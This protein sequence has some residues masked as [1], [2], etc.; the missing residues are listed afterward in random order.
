MPR[1]SK[2]KSSKHSSKELK[3]YSDSEKDLSFKDRKGKEESG[4]V[5]VS[6]DLISSEKRKLESKDGK[7][8]YSASGNGDYSDEYSSS[9]RRKDRADERATDRWNGGDDDHRGSGEGSKKSSKA[10][11][12]TKSKRKDENMGMYEEIEELKKGSSGGK[13]EGRHRDRDSSRKE[14][15]DGGTERDREKEKDRE[16]KTKEGRSEKSVGGDEHRP[17]VKQVIENTDLDAQGDLGSPEPDNLLERRMR[18]K[19]DSSIDYEKHQDDIGEFNNR[20]LSSREDT[21]KDGKQ[22]DEKRKD[23]RYK[24]KYR[25]EI[26]DRDS[27]HRDDRPKDERPA[28]DHLSSRSEDKHVKDE[29]DSAEM[30]NKKSKENDRDRDRHREL[31]VRDRD[32]HREH[33][34]DRG[35]DRDYDRDHDWDWDRDRDRDGDRDRERNRDRDRERERERD[36]ERDRDRDYDRDHDHDFDRDYVSSHLDDRAS[37]YKDST[38]AKKRSPDDRDD[39]SD[40][41]SRGSKARYSD[42][43][44][45]A[46]SGDRLDSDANKGRSHSRQTLVDPVTSNEKRRK[47]PSSSPRVGVDEYRHLNSDDLKYRE[48]LTD[49][50]SKGFPSKD[51]SGFSTGL[52]KGPK[53]RSMEKSTKLDDTLLGE[54]SNEK[55]SSSKASP[56]GLI[57]RS[58]SSSSIDRRY[59]NRSGAR[60]SLDIE[61]TGRRN[62]ASIDNRDFGASDDRHSRDLPSEKPLADESSP[63]DSNFYNRPNQGNS[64][65]IPSHSAF[66]AGVDSPFMGSHEDDGRMNSNARY[67][68]GDLNMGRGH[69]NAWRGVTNWN[70][71]LPNGFMPFQPGPPHAG[72]QGMMTQFPGPLFGVRPSLEI[73]H[74]GIPYHI[75]DADR[76]SSPMRPLGWQNMMDGSGPSHLHGWDNNGVFRDEPHLYAA[77]EWDQNRHP[78]NS[79]ARESSVDVWKGQNGDTKRDLRSPSHK[80]EATVDDGLAVQI[81][82]MSNQEDNRGDGI[83]GKFSETRSGATSSAEESTKVIREKK[84]GPSKSTKDN[85]YCLSR[86]YLSKLDISVELAR[87]ELYSQCMS[88]LNIDQSTMTDEETTVRIMSKDHLRA[89]VKSSANTL[90]SSHFPCVKK[91]VFQLVDVVHVLQRAMDLYKKQRTEA[92]GVP[93]LSKR[94]LNVVSESES[95]KLEVHTDVEM[96]KDLVPTLDTEMADASNSKMDVENA[97]PVMPVVSEVKSEPVVS[98][99]T[100]EMQNHNPLISPKLEVPT[101]ED[102]QEN[103]EEPQ[104]IFKEVKTE[105]ISSSEQKVIPPE[106]STAEIAAAAA[107]GA[108]SPDNASLPAAS[109][110]VEGEHIDE[111]SSRAN[112]GQSVENEEEG[113]TLGD[114]M[115][116]PVS[117]PGETSPKDCEAVMSGSN[118]SESVNLSR[119][120][121]SPESTH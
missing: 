121:H 116:G 20:R 13:G 8:L 46:L 118:E 84:L 85:V 22:R 36:R 62:T 114:G 81:G 29:K 30:Q 48:S 91:S 100:C 1:S 66:R 31:T 38:R 34:R 102:G 28:K 74:A 115:S 23:E 76:F 16:R 32:R 5:R 67:R 113:M 77:A 52:E 112:N 95:Q 90:Q 14:G 92:I 83:L 19:R 65:L 35:R 15:K 89:E 70:S 17:V 104:A 105:E 39:I 18:K 50:R 69:N 63:N 75:P 101:E 117:V 45:K 21:G 87:P 64:S 79:R 56:L 110:S 43:E 78:M 3:E 60:R 26:I 86:Y 119:I 9:K 41:P 33:D 47:S 42:L 58:P 106:D 99:P 44:K 49:Y 120:H 96:V 93:F 88:L 54:V 51:V 94:T 61:E 59:I 71:P 68:R 103:T 80:D 6:K 57:E 98:P 4:G 7:D 11:G 53:Y 27:K 10:S 82:Q 55:S 37:R 40:F 73:N 25:E 12:D 109:V 72:F 107:D 24:D 111:D 108:L 2:H 97:E